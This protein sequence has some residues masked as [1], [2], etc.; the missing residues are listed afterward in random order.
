MF[1]VC[2]RYRKKLFFTDK[3]VFRFSLLTF[4]GAL[5]MASLIG[6]LDAH[7]Q[8]EVKVGVVL[9]LSGN[10]SAYGA[11]A[12]RVL[13]LVEAQL[14][15]SQSR[16]HFSFIFRDGRCG[17]GDFA[18]LEGERLILQD[19]VNFLIV[20]CSGELM[21]VGPLAE[22]NR[23]V[24]I[25]YAAGHPAVR[26]VGSYVYR[27]YPS[28][29]SGIRRLINL[30]VKDRRRR[31]AILTEDNTFTNGIKDQFF[32]HLK[33]KIVF[34]GDYINNGGAD[35]SALL[36][37]ALE[38][39]PDAL[40]LNCAGRDSYQSLI[41][42]L[43]EKRIRIPIYTYYQPSDHFVI[44]NLR[45]EQEGVR[46]LSLPD[47]GRGD[48]QFR[49]VYARY[50]SNYPGVPAI[51]FMLRSAYDA[52]MILAE[53]VMAVGLAPDDVR[54]YLD[55]HTFRGANGKTTFD[56]NGDVEGVQFVLKEIR[57]GKPQLLLS[58]G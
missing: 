30:I 39:K 18:R 5:S 55:T 53:A 21:Q 41:K 17:E 27:T 37:E 49:N 2:L 29:D 11:D 50:L 33:A 8:Q 26:H 9:P 40:Y 28:I 32:Q 38:S 20:G 47:I 12:Q 43:R 52:A 34:S 10:F 1:R 15:K 46:F 23:I 25:G 57:G 16:F 35:Y 58:P 42:E 19:K 51:D 56:K 44:A 54:K 36:D 7:A 13:P 22:E 6:L 3:P 31:I 24:A 45:T 4:L 14:N 48:E